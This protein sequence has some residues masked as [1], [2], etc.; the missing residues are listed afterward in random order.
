MI[1]AVPPAEY[2]YQIYINPLTY[3]SLRSKYHTSPRC[4]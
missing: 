1:R 4:L 3:P 2:T